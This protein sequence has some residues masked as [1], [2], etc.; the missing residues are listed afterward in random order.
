M[1][2]KLVAAVI[3]A[4]AVTLAPGAAHAGEA[5][6]LARISV[7]YGVDIL[8]EAAAL[9]FGHSICSELRKGTPREV[10]ADAIYWKFLDAT[11]DQ[12]HGIAY[13]AQRELCPETA[14]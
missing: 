9:N 11:R 7:D 3:G 8:D 6:F 13:A 12:A 10:A 1:K 5:G 2:Q 4:A 14:Q